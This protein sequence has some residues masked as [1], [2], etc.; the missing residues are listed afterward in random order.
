MLIENDARRYIVQGIK[1]EKEI[2]GFEQRERMKGKIVLDCNEYNEIRREF[3]KVIGQI[4]SVAN[5]EGVGRDDLDVEILKSAENILRK[6]S[7][8]QSKAVRS[9]ASKIKCSFTNL[10][11]LFK[12]FDENIEVVDP[13]LKNN[14]DLAKALK[15][16]EESWEKGKEYFINSKK[17]SQLI[18]FSQIV[19]N[20]CEKYNELKSK[21]EDMDSEIFVIIPCLLVLNSLDGDDKKLCQTYFPPIESKNS[22]ERNHYLE[23][24]QLYSQ[25][26]KD[27]K[28]IYKLYNIVEMKVLE[29]PIKKEELKKLNINE[30]KLEELVLGIKGAAMNL[31]RYNPTDWNTLIET[32]LG[33]K[34]I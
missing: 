16:F 12:K 26:K 20:A 1:I 10:R 15:D 25:M 17:C 30:N 29:K 8:I 27:S 19:E 18:H 4:N 32:V 31:Q 5:P 21:M 14:T 23:I 7:N 2:S 3:V 13:Q 11:N 24:S 9:L 34:E 6:V 28:D 22:K 33:S